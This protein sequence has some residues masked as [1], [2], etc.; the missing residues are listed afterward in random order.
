MRKKNQHVKNRGGLTEKEV[1]DHLDISNFKKI[2]DDKIKDF[3][4]ILPDMNT[5]VVKKAF[6]KLPD[7]VKTT[8]KILSCYKEIIQESLKSNDAALKEFSNSC[9]TII[10]TLN[11]LIQKRRVKRKER[12]FIIEQLMDLVKIKASMVKENREWHAKIAKTASAVAG[13]FVSV[14]TVGGIIIKNLIKKK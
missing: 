12:Q 4:S 14:V 8:A 5:N 2:N 13:I 10:T 6:E 1:L 11:T 9:D 3:C 7:F